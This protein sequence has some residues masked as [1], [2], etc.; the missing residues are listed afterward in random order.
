MV[1]HVLDLGARH[2]VQFAVTLGIKPRSRHVRWLQRRGVGGDTGMGLEE[3][4]AVVSRVCERGDDRS[5]TGP[6]LM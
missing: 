5:N 1:Q 2:R 4:K 6:D 3:N